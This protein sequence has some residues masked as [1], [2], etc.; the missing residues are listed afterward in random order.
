MNKIFV[1]SDTHFGHKKVI[2][3][4]KEFRNFK[5][6]EDHDNEIVDRWN[7]VVNKKDTVWHLGDVLFGKESFA[8]LGRLNGVKKLVMGNHDRYPS[9]L[10]LDHFNVICGAA[11]IKNCI[12]T[13]IPVH[14]EQFKRYLYNMHGHLHSKNINDNRYINVS[15]E[16]INLTPILINELL[17]RRN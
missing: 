6:I 10:Y 3:F 9:K 7:S 11:E 4:E 13:H 12:L 17:D 5:S 8:I 14:E 2:E 16:Q 15:C 1:I